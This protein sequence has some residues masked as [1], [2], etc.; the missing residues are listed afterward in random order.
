MY[1]A[2]E[3]WREQDAGD[4]QHH[5]AGVQGVDSGEQFAPLR[6]QL[7]VDGS[8]AAEQHRRVQVR[9]DP[10]HAL[11]IAVAEHADRERPRNHAHPETEMPRHTA[12]KLGAR[13]K[14]RMMRLVHGFENAWCPCGRQW[15]SNSSAMITTSSTRP[16]RM[17]PLRCTPSCTKPYRSYSVI[18]FVF[19]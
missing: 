11:E 14:R 3:H 19:E 1:E 9:V 12:R 4:H 15:L 17:R 6:L 13:G 10:V 16:S 18:A 2:M 7:R 8:H 5:H